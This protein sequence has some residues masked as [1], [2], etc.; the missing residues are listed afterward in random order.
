LFRP[1]LATRYLE[2]HLDGRVDESE[3]LWPLL[4]FQLWYLLYVDESLTEAP[5]FGWAELAA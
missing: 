2:P 4:M 1:G 3:R 5:S